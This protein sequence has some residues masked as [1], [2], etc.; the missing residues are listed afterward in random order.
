MFNFLKANGGRQA[1]PAV[2]TPKETCRVVKC[3]RGNGEVFYTYQEWS[4]GKKEWVNI[5]LYKYSSGLVSRYMSHHS[6]YH[7]E[8]ITLHDICSFIKK[9]KKEKLDRELRKVVKEE[10]IEC[11]TSRKIN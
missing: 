5:P 6:T 3:T 7:L 10:V 8:E 4:F 2:E 9:E 11:C 1:Y